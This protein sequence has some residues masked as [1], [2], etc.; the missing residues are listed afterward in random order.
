MDFEYG[1]LLRREIYEDYHGDV[2][3]V[4]LPEAYFLNILFLALSLP[5]S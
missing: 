1:L 4:Y 3:M 2:G 5:R